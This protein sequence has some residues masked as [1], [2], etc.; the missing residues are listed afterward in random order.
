MKTYLKSIL[1]IIAILLCACEKDPTF[2]IRGINDNSTRVSNITAISAEVT[3]NIVAT[4]SGDYENYNHRNLEVYYSTSSNPFIGSYQVERCT[5]T[6]YTGACTIRLYGLEPGT[7]YYYAPKLGN[8]K[9]KV[10]SFKTPLELTV[11]T[12]AYSNLTA[13]SVQL[14]GSAVILNGGYLDELGILVRLH[15]P[16]ITIKNYDYKEYSYFGKSSGTYPVTKSFSGLYTESTYYYRTY[17]KGKNGKIYYGEVK[18]FKTTPLEN[19]EVTTGSYSRLEPTSVTLSGSC[20]LNNGTKLE[21]A[22]ILIKLHDPDISISSYDAGTSGTS[23][24]YSSSFTGLYTES[25]YYYR[26]YAKDSKGKYYYGE[27]KSFKTPALPS[28]SVYT[29]YVSGLTD[30]YAM[31]YGSYYVVNPGSKLSSAGILIRKENS[32]VNI[33]NYD[34][35]SY[36]YTTSFYSEFYSLRWLTT[37]YYR[38]YATDINGNTYYGD[39][40]SFSTP[41]Y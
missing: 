8:Q 32:Y 10:R 28:F 37:Y 33:Y 12:G 40:R 19:I 1:A 21:K 9:G 39:T 5:T 11:T 24:N 16:D 41:L 13:K 17:A 20:V 18:S 14:E 3:T 22:G 2:A 35:R 38:A 7:T 23:T 15:N 30:S 4:Q 6:V 34:F 27:V 25:T 26:A 36:E 29:G 31:I